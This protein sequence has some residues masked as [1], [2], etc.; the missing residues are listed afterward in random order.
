MDWHSSVRIPYK[1]LNNEAHNVAF[2]TENRV[3]E[4]RDELYGGQ[5]IKRM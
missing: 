5:R 1:T 2:E 3:A 4:I